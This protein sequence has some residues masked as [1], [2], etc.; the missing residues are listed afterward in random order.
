MACSHDDM[1]L[2]FKTAAVM[3][4]QDTSIASKTH[5]CC[6]GIVSVGNP[7]PPSSRLHVI[8]SLSAVNTVS[9]G[10]HDLAAAL[11]LLESKRSMS[12]CEQE[13]VEV[14]A[15]VARSLWATDVAS[16]AWQEMLA[17][18]KYFTLSATVSRHRNKRDDLLFQI[19]QSD[20]TVSPSSSVLLG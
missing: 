6:H 7:P 18:S 11:L 19:H 12:T 17:G 16:R 2:L 15:V 3:V 13:T 5:H 10:L 20:S 4:V 9:V 8:H 1:H 14:A